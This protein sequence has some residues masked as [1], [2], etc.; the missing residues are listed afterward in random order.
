MDDPEIRQAVALYLEGTL[1]EAEAARRAGI[2]RALL[3][4]YARTSGIAS[5]PDASATETGK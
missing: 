2:P 4:E 3:R 5:L 1:T